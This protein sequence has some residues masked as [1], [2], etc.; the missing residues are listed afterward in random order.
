MANSFF[1]INDNLIIDF[2]KGEGFNNI[3]TNTILA[4][5]IKI[6]LFLKRI[7][8]NSII[9]AKHKPYKIINKNCVIEALKSLGIQICNIQQNGGNTPLHTI[10]HN[11]E[12]LYSFHS[13]STSSTPYNN[14]CG[15]KNS[16]SQCIEPSVIGSTNHPVCNQKGSG[17]KTVKK[18]RL[19]PTKLM[20]KSKTKK[21]KVFNNNIFNSIID[22]NSKI[23]FSKKAK[24]IVN[25]AIKFYV[26]KILKEIKKKKKYTNISKN[27]RKNAQLEKKINLI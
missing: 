12:N 1:K 3:D 2:I 6:I 11:G 21:K 8:F 23:K 20:Q 10:T 13:N 9:F 17:A 22:N 14:F 7:I 18:F 27:I 25:M 5:K 16:W 15:G 19:S 4:L 26:I 24:E